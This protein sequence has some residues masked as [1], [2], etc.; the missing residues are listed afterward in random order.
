MW[1]SKPTPEDD[2]NAKFDGGLAFLHNNVDVTLGEIS[3][4]GDLAGGKA[5][6]IHFQLEHSGIFNREPSEI[7]ADGKLY[8]YDTMGQWYS[9]GKFLV[10]LE[11]DNHLKAEIKSGAC[12]SEETFSNPYSYE[13]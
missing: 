7:K 4:G 11:D 13:R 12:G 1:F 9:Q 5:G 6:V 8:C 10:K 2:Y 3:V